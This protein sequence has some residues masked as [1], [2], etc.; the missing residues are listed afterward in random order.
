[1]MAVLFR[2][3][4]GGKSRARRD[5]APGDF[6]RQGAESAKVGGDFLLACV[7]RRVR[8]QHGG[9]RAERL[10]RDLT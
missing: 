2:F 6:N 1:M 7:G 8:R 5:D 10:R 3:R 9:V 4:P